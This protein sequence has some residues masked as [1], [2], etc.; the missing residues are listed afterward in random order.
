MSRDLVNRNLGAGVDLPALEAPAKVFLADPSTRAGDL[1]KPGH[2]QQCV[3][4]GDP[5]DAGRVS[6]TSA[7][8]SAGLRPATVS[9]W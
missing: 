8:A 7:A 5:T 4:G 2:E 1:G 9:T 6:G 3:L